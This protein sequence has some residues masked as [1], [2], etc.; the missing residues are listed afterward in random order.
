MRIGGCFHFF[1]LVHI[2]LFARVDS[3]RSFPGPFTSRIPSLICSRVMTT[4]PLGSIS[5]ADSASTLLIF[6]AFCCFQRRRPLTGK[7]N[8]N[9]RSIKTLVRPSWRV[10]FV[11]FRDKQQKLADLRPEQPTGLPYGWLS[12]PGSLC[13]FFGQF[14]VLLVYAGPNVGAEIIGDLCQRISDSDQ[15]VLHPPNLRVILA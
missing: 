1:R 6:C 13:C 8:N 12:S 9:G 7:V 10:R 5:D 2:T 11:L 15:E 4:S 3:G 14:D